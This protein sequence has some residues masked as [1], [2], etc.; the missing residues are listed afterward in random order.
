MFVKTSFRSFRLNPLFNCYTI[1]YVFDLRYGFMNHTVIVSLFLRF[2][3]VNDYFEPNEHDFHLNKRE[4]DMK[5]S[6]E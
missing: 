2:L 3:P 1:S 5:N 4:F 6:V